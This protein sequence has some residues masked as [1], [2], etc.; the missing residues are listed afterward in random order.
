[1]HVHDVTDSIKERLRQNEQILLGGE[2]L[3]AARE[4][5]DRL[6]WRTYIERLHLRENYPGIPGCRFYRDDQACR[7]ASPYRRDTRRRVS[8]L[9]GS[10]AGERPLYTQ[11]LSG[12]FSG[13]N[14]AA[15]GY[16][17]MSEATRAQAMRMA[18]ESGK[19]T[20]SGKVKLMQETHG[21]EQAGF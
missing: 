13:R 14:L 10:P 2:G 20:I 3:F 15:F 9:Y 18:A 19:T 16:D 7:S 11:S 6:V 21:K 1:M 8:G 4:A 17:M 12:A 5:V